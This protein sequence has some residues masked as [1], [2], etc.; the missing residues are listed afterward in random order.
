MNVSRK[1]TE[2]SLRVST[3]TVD[4]LGSASTITASC[5]DTYRG[6]VGG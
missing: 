5:K 4:K 3:S 2:R 1:A 6:F